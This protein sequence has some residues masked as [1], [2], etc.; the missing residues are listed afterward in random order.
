V[1]GLVVSVALAGILGAGILFLLLRPRAPDVPDR[2]P[3]TLRPVASADGGG[4]TTTPLSP[5][6]SLAPSPRTATTLPPEI[7]SVRPSPPAPVVKR[8]SAPSLAPVIATAPPVTLAVPRPSPVAVP[9]TLPATAEPARP[10][11]PSFPGAGKVETGATYFEKTLGYER[12][13]PLQFDA[14]AGAVSIPVV[15]MMVIEKRRG[16]NEPRVEVRAVFPVVDCPRGG[17][18]WSYRVLVALL[19]GSGRELHR[20][21]D[22]GSCTS[23]TKTSAASDDV[24]RVLLGEIR[25]VR[26][27]VDASKN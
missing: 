27:R 1:I 26:V 3:V 8:A 5:P 23:E 12:N 16:R 22:G 7:P 14:H 10:A 15:E 19:D 25:G 6:A 17:G 18:K 2:T 13:L 21:G 4:L 11:A 9:P 24:P 20:F